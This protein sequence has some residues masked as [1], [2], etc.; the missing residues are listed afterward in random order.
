M[1]I[2]WKFVHRNFSEKSCNMG[3]NHF[4]V[5]PVPILVKRMKQIPQGIPKVFADAIGL[6]SIGALNFPDAF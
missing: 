2:I 4:P 1:V 6:Y 5:I 3:G